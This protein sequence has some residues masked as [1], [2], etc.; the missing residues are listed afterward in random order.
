MVLGPTL[1]S[2][3]TRISKA[4]NEFASETGWKAGEYKI[5][6]ALNQKKWGLI[7]VFFVARD[8]EGSSER[9]MWGRA[10]DH[11]AKSLKSGPEIGYSIGLSVH[12]WD[13]VKQ[14]GIYSIPLDYVEEEELLPTTR[15]A[16]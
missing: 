3:L 14:G 8:F 10:W 1:R 6:F 4:F 16:N 15:L 13:Q 11:L 12:S 7:R 5:L 9:D 2:A